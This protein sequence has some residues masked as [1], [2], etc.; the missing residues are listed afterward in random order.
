MP[1]QQNEEHFFRLEIQLYTVQDPWF[2]SQIQ[3]KAKVSLKCFSSLPIVFSSFKATTS[4][5][6]AI[7]ND[8]L[9]SRYFR[10]GIFS[11]NWREVAV[12][13]LLNMLRRLKSDAGLAS[14]FTRMCCPRRHLASWCLRSLVS[15]RTWH[16]T[17]QVRISPVLHCIMII[18]K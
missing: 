1:Q 14:A 2:E 7:A 12:A 15:S 4:S 5:P 17:E 10:S 9:F 11:K 13:M 6:L 3:F 8:D 18:I 16:V